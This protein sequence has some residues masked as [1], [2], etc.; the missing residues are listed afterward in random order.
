MALLL[1]FF[2]NIFYFNL[3]RYIC[4]QNVKRFEQK[5]EAYDIIL[6]ICFVTV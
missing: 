6:R 3:V 1:S 5:L 2:W 4:T